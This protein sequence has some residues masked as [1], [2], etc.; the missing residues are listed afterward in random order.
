MNELAPETCSLNSKFV[1]WYRSACTHNIHTHTS[2]HTQGDDDDDDYD[3]YSDKLLRR[4]QQGWEIEAKDRCG[5]KY[6]VGCWCV[7]Q[8][9]ELLGLKLQLHCL[10]N[11][12]HLREKTVKN[13]PVWDAEIPHQSL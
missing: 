10:D 8:H 7:I 13:D 5:V 1:S 12:K 2:Q 11:K 3:D 6:I 4:L 9:Y